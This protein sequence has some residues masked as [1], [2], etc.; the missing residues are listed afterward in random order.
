MRALPQPRGDDQRGAARARCDAPPDGVRGARP[1]PPRR[2][3]GRRRPAAALYCCYEL[4]YRG[5]AGVDDALGVGAVA[6]RAARA[7]SRRSS[8]TRCSSRLGPPR[9]AGGARRRWT[10]RC[11]RSPTP[12]TARR[13]RTY[14][15]RHATLEQVLRVPGAP[16]GLPAQGGRPALVGAAAPAAGRRRRRWWRSRPTSTA[17]GGP[18]ASTH[19][20]SPTRWRRSGLERATARTST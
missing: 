4:H 17:A 7:S 18:S 8:R 14:I 1:R 5:L 3:A 12:T 6:A 10:S 16:L 13:C 20:C 2:P 15:E 9:D 19:S 11:A